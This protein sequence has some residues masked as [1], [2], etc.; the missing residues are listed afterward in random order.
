MK[1]VILIFLFFEIIFHN[2]VM[3]QEVEEFAS[4][5]T[6]E[7]FGKLFYHNNDELLVSAE[8]SDYY[9]LL[10][11]D[12]N[13]EII[14][15]ELI[16]EKNNNF[17]QLERHPDGSA[18]MFRLNYS[19]DTVTLQGAH[20]GEDLS[21]EYIDFEWYETGVENFDRSEWHWILNKD[22]TIFFAH[23]V[24]S[25]F[26]KQD[27]GEPYH[28]PL[29]YGGM[30][31]SKF[32]EDGSFLKE[33][34]LKDILHSGFLYEMIPTPDTLGF[35]LILM[36]SNATTAGVKNKCVTYD[37][38]MDTV[39]IKANVDELSYP[40]LCSLQMSYFCTNPYNGKT[41][42]INDE[43]FPAYNNI[44]AH[45]AD[46]MMGMW[47]EDFNQK[48]YTYGLITPTSSAGGYENSIVF[49]EN[50]GVYM[51]GGMDKVGFCVY[52]LYI[53]YLDENL[54]K[55]KEIY[56]K[57]DFLATD[58]RCGLCYS[59]DDA[60]VFNCHTFDPK[61]QEMKY[62][63]YRVPHE[64]FL[65]IDEAHDAGF[66]VAVAYPNPGGST[67]N[68]RTALTGSHVELYDT[69]GRLVGRQEITGAVTSINTEKLPSGIYVWKVI[70]DGSEAESGKWVKE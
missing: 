69:G 34:V 55:L 61:T 11:Y 39:S 12:N 65:G 22:N 1:K 28:I 2:A 4:I 3:A 41:Y 24:D 59:P 38:E 67:L 62:Y 31:I 36:A 35:R 58:F 10:K 18:W 9:W 6:L 51:I 37:S 42:S 57:D 44:P 13:G 32:G 15:S 68:I 48:A 56:Y 60:L 46:I 19:N 54:N 43:T 5:D 26:Y 23:N 47:D 27:S 40:H 17:A 29:S 70:K 25:L 63:L 7:Y 45:E 52:N 21:L 14:D 50:G 30:R 49:D 33:I 66:A 20:I 8:N 16:C 53:V 64:A